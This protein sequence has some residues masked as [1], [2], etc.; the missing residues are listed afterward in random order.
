VNL[1]IISNMFKD[2]ANSSNANSSS[3][4]AKTSMPTS[5]G[6]PLSS[7]ASIVTGPPSVKPTSAPSWNHSESQVYLRQHL[8][9]TGKS[10][11]VEETH[12]DEDSDDDVNKSN[13]A[14][15]WQGGKLLFGAFGI[16][17]A[18]LTYGHIQED[19]FRFRSEDGGRFQYVWLLQVLESVSNVAVGWLARSYFGGTPGVNM[20]LFWSSGSSQVFAKALTSLAL[21]AGLSFPV[22]T[23]AKSAKMVPVMLGQLCLGGTSYSLQDYLL[24]G[25]IVLGTAMLSLGEAHKKAEGSSSAL[26]MVFII[27]SLIADGL[28]AGLQK[29]LKATSQPST[30]DF[31]L[32]TNIAMATTAFA[33]AVITGDFVHGWRFLNE[34]PSIRSLIATVC[35]CSAIGQSFVFFVVAQFD[36]LVCATITTTRKILSVVWSISTKGHVISTQGCLGLGM[37]ISGLLFEIQS[38]A[39]RKR[40]KGESMAAH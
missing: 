9:E 21:S 16:Y 36:P 34:N 2:N 24:A 8:A 30:Y 18:Y 38:K 37:A 23:L 26:G 33:I 32:F 17:S 27:L 14:D 13:A 5:G 11:A 39:S 25:A 20:S 10:L 15:R 29:R 3:G 6:L 12:S 40:R 22:C 35:L 4:T 1:S 7:V 31:L 28:T 19:V